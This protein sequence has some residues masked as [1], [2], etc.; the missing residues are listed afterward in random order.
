MSGIINCGIG[1]ILLLSVVSCAPDQE[2]MTRSLLEGRWELAMAQVNGEATDRLEKLYFVFLPDT[3][4]QTNI[5][6]SEQN[7][8]YQ[9]DGPHIKQLSSP[10]VEYLMQ[11]LTDSS[12]VLQTEIRG[13]TFDMFLG[14]S[15]PKAPPTVQQENESPLSD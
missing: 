14:R 3:S 11:E 10:E 1:I 13:A 8:K 5:L 6:G 4:L 2:V 12:L 15:T 7:F 9:V